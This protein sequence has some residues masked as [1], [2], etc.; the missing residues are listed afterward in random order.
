MK[1]RR[2]IALVLLAAVLGALGAVVA[3][4]GGG[5][6]P[7]SRVDS[8]RLFV[9]RADK[10]Y[11]KPGETVTL[12]ALIGDGRKVKDRAPKNFW[13][14][15]ACVNPREDLYYLCFA[16]PGDGGRQA[17][18]TRLVP[19]GPLAAIA[20]DG[21][22]EAGASGGGANPF[23]SIPTD[24]DLSPFLPEG[25]TFSFPM[26]DDAIQPREG[27]SAPY[28]LVIVFN[29]LCA[30]Q[31]RFVA[32]DL[33]GGA[34]Q[35]PVACTDDEGNKLPPSEY[36]VGISRVYSYA[37]RLNANPVIEK[38]LLEQQEIDP[39][40]GVVVE[41]CTDGT[42]ERECKENKIDLRMAESSWEENPGDV[43][44]EGPLREQIWVTY[45]S[46]IGTFAQDARLLFDT[47]KGRVA[48]SDVSFRAPRAPASG[49]LWAV[50]HDNRGGAA[51]VV[52][53]IHVR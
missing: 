43:T 27:A 1:V 37:E 47:R 33:E 35:V 5:F 10:P 41:R 34:Q 14:P 42:R 9:V 3:C 2:S 44:R 21:G 24:V 31:V 7:Q 40:V 17:G 11:A 15:I 4:G 20:G 26:P 13:I 51:W 16:P 29:V 46:D 49:T 52:V 18:A 38:V 6:D 36:V 23:A 30:G 45:Y 19:L 48:D 53:P 8:L 22:V 32:R 12:E 25:P 50:V 28:G 39:A